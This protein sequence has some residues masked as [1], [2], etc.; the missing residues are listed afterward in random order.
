MGPV[1]IAVLVIVL[2]T[3]LGAWVVAVIH[4]LRAFAALG[5]DNRGLRWMAVV[6][7]PFAA[8]RMEGAAGR[9]AAVVNKAI[10]VFIVCIIVAAATI[11]L[12]TNFTRIS[13]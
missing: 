11:S 2:A 5:E 4:A 1:G 10:V 8:R 12:S 13:R 7:W 3:A 6:A 9:H